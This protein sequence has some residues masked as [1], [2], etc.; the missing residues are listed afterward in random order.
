MHDAIKQHIFVIQHDF[1][2]HVSILASSMSISCM[3]RIRI[4]EGCGSEKINA[5]RS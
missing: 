2:H 1:Q 3:E 5:I 4:F